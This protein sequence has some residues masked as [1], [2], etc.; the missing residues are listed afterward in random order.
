MKISFNNAYTK[1]VETGLRPV[2]VIINDVS[3]IIND[4][5]AIIKKV[6][7]IFVGV[8][9]LYLFTFLLSSCKDDHLINN[10]KYLAGVEKAFDLKKSLAVNRDSALFSVFKANLSSEQK[11]ALKFLYAYMPLSDLADYN[12]NFFLTNVN[13]SL[14][15]RKETTWGKNIPEDIFLHYVLPFRINNENLDSFRI[16]YYSKLSE[17]IKGKSL[18]E[19]A[20]EINHWCHEKVSYQP[21]DDRTSG[22]VSTILSS[23]GR[24]GEESTLTVSALRTV[25]IPARQVYTPRWAH[26]DDNHAWVEIWNDGKWYYMG[27]CEPEPVLDLGWFTEPARRAMLIHTKSF[28]AFT[29]DENAINKSSYFTDVNNLAK[30]A[31]SKKIFVKV[32]DKNEK[33]VSNASVEYQL[34]N[35]SEFYPLA[36]VPTNDMGISQ[37]ETGLGDLLIWAHKDDDFDFKKI[38]VGETDTLL[39]KLSKD[40]TCSKSLDLDLDVPIV[41]SP[42]PGPSADLVEKNSKRIINEN[43][44]RQTYIDS[45]MKPVD[46]KALALKLK[47]DTSRVIRAISRSMGNYREVTSFLSETPDSLLNNALSMLEILPDKDLRDVR[48]STFSDHLRLCVYQ[49]VPGM[50]MNN[51]FFISNVLNPRIANE[52]LVPW[53]QYFQTHLASGFKSEA[54][55]NPSLIVKY[56]NENIRIAEDENYYGT[57]LTPIGVCEL[58]VSDADSRAICF[59]AICRALGIPSRLEPGR[60]VP[61]YFFDKKWIDVYFSDQ[62]PPDLNKGYIRFHSEETK[63]VPEYYIQFTLARFE[64]GR[65]KTLEYD[66]NKKITDFKDELPLP[67]GH[68]MLVTGNRLNDSKILSN[69]S[70]FNLKENEHKIIDVKIRKDLSE[71]K[72]LGNIDIKKVN[73]L[74]P[75]SSTSQACSNEKGIVIFWIEPE[76]EPAKHIFNDLPFLK[77][78]LDKWGG[79]FLFLS[80]SGN[81]NDLAQ[82]IQ[83]VKGLPVNTFS[84]IDDNL[85]VMKNLVKLEK[86]SELNLPVTLVADKDGNIMFLSTGYRIGIGEQIL[87]YLK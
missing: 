61:Q 21:A 12:G 70:F 2:S 10:S 57:P 27:A 81:R 15:S 49:K 7:T 36:V 84:G 75:V 73:S 69:I 30:Y 4:V 78:E 31:V 9:A 40:L 43:T 46:A 37:F 25:G 66:F 18:G 38:S 1:H 55:A 54:V 74:Y 5:S 63:P 58:K 82:Q 53:R 8:T 34:Y 48:S 14:R 16:V 64:K 33:P 86:P 72:I 26:T 85:M 42:L 44:I 79:K 45:W 52:L 50:E 65:Y 67:P 35:Y 11:E 3:A 22:P 19:A 62:I 80:D 20:L 87:K 13:F 71:R 56:L 47:T 41:R 60:N 24:C 29:G 28:G 17:R 76:K 39:L 6:R 59:V 68:Y 77:A 23:R 51:D 83:S 32:I